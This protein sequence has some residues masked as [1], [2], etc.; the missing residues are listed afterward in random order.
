[1]NHP[2]INCSICNRFTPRQHQEKHHLI[3][4]SK[5]GED[6]ILVCR[7][8]GDTLHQ[9]FTNSELKYQLNT[10][11]KIKNHSRIKTWIAW[12]IKRPNQFGFCMKKKKKR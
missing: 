7:D 1:M 5:G 2:D 9:F 8:C 11:N 4:K 10:L 6:I 3:P 12:V